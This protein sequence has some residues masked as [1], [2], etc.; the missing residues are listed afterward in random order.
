[1]LHCYM[2]VIDYGLRAGGGIGDFMPPNTYFNDSK[3]TYYIR[4]I[5][6]VIFFMV[7]IITFFNIIFGIIIDTFGALRE[8]N[9]EMEEDMRNVCY[10]C[11]IER[12]D[13]SALD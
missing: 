9:N 4:L 12:Q 2:A 3:L 8:Q 5:H 13:V 11:G 7:I 10:I 6:D 1:M